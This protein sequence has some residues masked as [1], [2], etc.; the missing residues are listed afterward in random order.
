MDDE[1][2]LTLSKDEDTYNVVLG[3]PATVTIVDDEVPNK[4][5]AFATTTVNRTWLIPEDS[6]VGAVLG[7]PIA[8]TDPEGDSLTYSL[9]R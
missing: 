4:P 9:S 3:N 2:T 8:A 6:P 7:D 1:V 5:P